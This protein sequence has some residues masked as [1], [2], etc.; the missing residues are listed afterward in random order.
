MRQLTW[1][2]HNEV[3]DHLLFDHSVVLNKTE[4][5]NYLRG[6]TVEEIK[7]FVKQKADVSLNKLYFLNSR[8]V[9]E[10]FHLSEEDQN[11]LL[12]LLNPK[13]FNRLPDTERTELVK[14]AAFFSSEVHKT[15]FGENVIA[16]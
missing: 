8:D 11:V 9:I 1:K 14:K 3:V 13:R 2:N 6:V 7:D 15:V 5:N 12:V 10:H 4:T 16:Y